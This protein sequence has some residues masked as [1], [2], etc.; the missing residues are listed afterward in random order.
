VLVFADI[1]SAFVDPGA[2]VGSIQYDNDTETFGLLA[3]DSATDYA[4]VQLGAVISAGPM[5][6]TTTA[7]TIAANAIAVTNRIGAVA[8][9]ASG[10][11]ATITGGTA[12]QILIIT[13]QDAGDEIIITDGTGRDANE[14]HTA[15]SVTV[16]YGDALVLKFNGVWWYQINAVDND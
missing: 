5:I 7:A 9:T 16:T 8:I 15:G 6:L 2:S 10:T 14:I 4:A 13:A 3:D 11:L 12:G 1:G